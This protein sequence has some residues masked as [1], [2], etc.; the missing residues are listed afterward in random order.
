MKFLNP[1]LIV[2]HRGASGDAPEN[3][4]E[5][6]NLAWRQGADAIECDVRKT[7][8]NRLVCIHDRKTGRDGGTALDVSRSTLAELREIDGVP[9]KGAPGSNGRIPLLEDVLA[10]A[11]EHKTVFAEIK[12]GPA[13]V[14]LL[15]GVMKKS[16]FPE[17]RIVVISFNKETVKRAG[18]VL[19][20]AKRLLVVKFKYDRVKN[21]WSPSPQEITDNLKMIGAD[22][23]DVSDAE[24]V[25]VD[26]VRQM[27]DA[28]FEAHV[29][30][31]NDAEAAARYRRCGVDSITTDRPRAVRD[32]ID[33]A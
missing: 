32:V 4:I 13:T 15:P 30:T 20:G 1:T 22:G 11:P 16:K 7:L 25:D 9:A 14:A 3:T 8:D 28:G 17:N 2:A 24:T 19:P 27:H 31:V 18:R 23:A 33:P 29:W 10:S 6:F 21:R 5:A 26:F 12:S